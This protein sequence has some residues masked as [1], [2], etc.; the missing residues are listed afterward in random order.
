MLISKPKFE[1]APEGLFEA[2]IVDVIDLGNETGPWGVKPKL[3]IRLEID[4]LNSKGA[5]FVVGSKFTAS[6]HEKSGFH[7]A[8]KGMFGRGPSS[9]FNTDALLGKPCRV[10]IQ[11]DERE[12]ETYANIASWL[13]SEKPIKPSGKYIREQD[14]PK[15]EQQSRRPAAQQ[16][17]PGWPPESDD[18]GEAA[19]DPSVPF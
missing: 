16:E 6:I 11:H 15:E 8:L 5:R 4:A 2:V 17:D 1:L 10:L 9:E 7:K 3:R 14:R 12:G 19:E 13:K 18:P